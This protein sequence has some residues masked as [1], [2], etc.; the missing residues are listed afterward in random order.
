MNDEHKTCSNLIIKI[1]LPRYEARKEMGYFTELVS[2]LKRL[3]KTV[4]QDKKVKYIF[5]KI[6]DSHAEGKFA[7]HCINT[8]AIFYSSIENIAS[9][10]D[11]LHGLHPAQAC[12]IGIEYASY[13]KKPDS[14]MAAQ[15][16]KSK[17]NKFSMCRYG[18]NHYLYHDRNG[19]IFFTNRN[20][21]ENF[22]MCPRDIASSEDLI[23]EF[24][25]AQAFYIGLLAGLKKNNPAKKSASSITNK[26]QHLR[27]VK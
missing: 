24:D 9:D 15:N 20:T 6:I 11:I 25:A 2:K 18:E 12:F 5:Y 10:P 21:N 13:L 1:Q 4:T 17:L 14:S 27:V 23:V 7:I 26:H 3:T 16:Q 19:D 8:S 22:I